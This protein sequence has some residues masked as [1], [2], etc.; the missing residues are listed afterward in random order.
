MMRTLRIA[1][2]A[3]VVSWG[4]FGQVPAARAEFEAAVIRVNNSG[5][6]EASFKLLPSG[7]FTATNILMIDIF[8]FAFKVRKETTAGAPGWFNTDRF[9]ITGR[10][11]A[12][13]A[14]DTFREMLGTLLIQELKLK[15]H[16][17]P[18]AMNAYALVL[19]KGGPKLQK[20]AGTGEAECQPVGE[21]GAQFGGA[22]RACTNLTMADLAEA[23]PDIA[24]G[25][26]NKTVVNQ[27]GLAGNYDFRLDWVG[28]NNID[29]VGGLTMFG[30]VEKL[31]LKLE[32][33][34]LTLPVVVIDH[35]EKLSEP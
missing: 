11:P 8:H 3:L 16:V 14:E 15:V 26:V 12:N 28:R 20:A 27:T 24:P 4:A 13:S 5:Q 29:T 17:E 25:Y 30:A 10:A 6:A 2:L 34:K 9:D 31:G 35:V 19:G 32:E 18:T 23:L 22:H 1:G 21:Q 7:L 33:K